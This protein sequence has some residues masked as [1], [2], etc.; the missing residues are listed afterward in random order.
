MKGYDIKIMFAQRHSLAQLVCASA[1][2]P[3]SIRDTLIVQPYNV[4]AP[5][6]LP[7]R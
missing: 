3:S 4:F 2:T 5:S 6:L 7:Y 1:E